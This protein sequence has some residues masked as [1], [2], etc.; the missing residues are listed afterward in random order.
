MWDDEMSTRNV[1]DK[2]TKRHNF[3]DEDS[4]WCIF[5]RTGGPGG[6]DAEGSGGELQRTGG[7]RRTRNQTTRTIRADE[8]DESKRDAD[9][10]GC[11]NK[12]EMY[13]GCVK[14]M[15]MQGLYMQCKGIRIR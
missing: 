7:T 10:A 12:V 14:S 11:D 13:G 4:P 8:T 1:D 2:E 3:G 5:I 15:C 9:D 6:L